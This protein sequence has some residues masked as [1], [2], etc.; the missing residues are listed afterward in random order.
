M[1]KLN[2]PVPAGIAC[3]GCNGTTFKTS[4]QTF[5]NGTRHLRMDCAECGRFVRFTKQT[6]AALSA[7]VEA[8]AEKA[9][10]SPPWHFDPRPSDANA[11]ETA[12]PPFGWEWLGHIRQADGVW[13]P[14]A[15]ASTLHGCWCALLTY[16]GKGDLLCQAIK[17]VRRASA[18]QSDLFPQAGFTGWKRPAGGRGKWARVV[19]GA[20]QDEVLD[21]LLDSGPGDKLVTPSG[22][23]PNRGIS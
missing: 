5:A 17:P 10:E 7:A 18:E 16:P 22:A 23:D 9:T 15:L 12:P 20:T 3:S 21:R 4:W 19:E 13:R 14:V 8:E 2:S 11:R 6:P 1:Q